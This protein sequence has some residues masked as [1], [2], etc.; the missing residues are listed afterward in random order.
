MRSFDLKK[1]LGIDH[2]DFS[3][4]EFEVFIQSRIL[5]DSPSNPFMQ[6][7]A[8]IHDGDLTKVK[9]CISSGVEVKTDDFNALS[10]VVGKYRNPDAYEKVVV[11]KIVP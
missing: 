11:R 5:G 7:L 6:F 3:K 2:D 10:Y 4:K 1:E 8:A 9:T